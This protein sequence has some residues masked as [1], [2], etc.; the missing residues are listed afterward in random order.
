M[1]N[2]SWEDAQRYVA[3][4]SEVTGKTYRLLSESE[5]EYATRAGTTTAYPWGDNIES[6]GKAN[7]NGCGSQWDD[8]ADGARRLICSEKV[9]SLRHG[10]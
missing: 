2:V 7:C 1:I 5:Y 9:W 4:L 6:N 10:G 8:Q 3:W